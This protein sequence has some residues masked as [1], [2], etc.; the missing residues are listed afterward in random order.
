MSFIVR[1]IIGN[2]IVILLGMTAMAS[3][4]TKNGLWIESS[5]AW[6]CW[7]PRRQLSASSAAAPSNRWPAGGRP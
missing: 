4:N 1:V 3:L 6:P 7:P 2:T 5:S